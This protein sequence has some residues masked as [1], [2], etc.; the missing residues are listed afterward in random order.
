MQIKSL[1]ITAKFWK[2][3]DNYC[4]TKRNCV[5]TL[6]FDGWL[7]GFHR[8]YQYSFGAIRLYLNIRKKSHELEDHSYWYQYFT[9]STC[10]PYWIWSLNNDQ[11]LVLLQPNHLTDSIHTFRLHMVQLPPFVHSFHHESFDCVHNSCGIHPRTSWL[12]RK[13]Q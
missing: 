5:L 2:W 12:F 7:D 3:I 4:W 9:I 1:I 13:I 10:H 8:K 6:C 11:R